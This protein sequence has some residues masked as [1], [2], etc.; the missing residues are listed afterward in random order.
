MVPSYIHRDGA[1]GFMFAYT[2]ILIGSARGLA[3]SF[4]GRRGRR[5][6]ANVG[7]S[8]EP[9]AIAVMGVMPPQYPTAS[10]LNVAHHSS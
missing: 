6:L 7:L 9:A 5:P 3:A 10:H 8:C 1:S 4:V 2:C